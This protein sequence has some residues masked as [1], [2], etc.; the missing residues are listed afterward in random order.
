MLLQQKKFKKLKCNNN[1]RKNKN[2][3]NEIII[4]KIT[5]KIKINSQINYQ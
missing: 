2:K 5:N 1:N 3:R 4:E